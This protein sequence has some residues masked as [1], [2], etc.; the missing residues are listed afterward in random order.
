MDQ[1]QK[2]LREMFGTV[3]QFLGQN[4]T[5][6]NGIPAFVNA[7][8]DLQTG[9]GEIDTEAGK[10]ATPTSGKT[11]VKGNARDVLED[12]TQEIGDQL[13]ALAA[14]TEDAELASQ[15][16][17]TRSTLD[18]ATGGDL[19]IIGKRIAG[20]AT[21]NLTALADYA[22]LAAD[23]AELQD[24][25]TDFEPLKDAPRVAIVGRAGST[26]T[27]PGRI[28][29]TRAILRNRIDKLITKFRKTQPQFY[30]GY[31]SARVIINRGGNGGT[32][33]ASPTP[34]VP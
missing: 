13:A 31:L 2:N 28:T 22:V 26:A 34:P 6:W 18:Q 4:S 21:I 27:L 30:A 17:M 33:P 25:I 16:T 1:D 20:L 11:V 12:A 23:V 7:A 15:V 32:T 3:A 8:A 10:Q 9:I 29:A 24:A 14:A 19:L 5:L